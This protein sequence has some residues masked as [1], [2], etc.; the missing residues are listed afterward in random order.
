MSASY[1]YEVLEGGNAEE[2]EYFTAAQEAINEGSAWKFQGSA[3]RALVSAITEGRCLLG[4]EGAWDAYGNYVP[5]RTE[6]TPGTKGSIE[7]V[8]RHCG[9]D[10]AD[11]IEGV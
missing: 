6:V 11:H 5:S 4:R 2:E 1:D 7:Y 3:G 9:Q 10:W 8:V